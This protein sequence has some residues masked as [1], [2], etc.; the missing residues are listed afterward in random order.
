[1]VF[2]AIFALALSSHAHATFEPGWAEG[3]QAVNIELEHNLQAPDRH[4]PFYHVHPAPK[5]PGVYLWDSSFISLI[6][7]HHN[8]RIAKEVVQSV[9]VNQK[10]DGRIPQ[11]VSILGASKWTNPPVLSYA[12]AH[13]ASGTNDAEFAEK[14]Y[15]PLK[16]YQNWLWQARRLQNGLFFWDHAYESGLDNSPRFGKRDE[17]WYRDTKTLAAIDLSSYVVLDAHSMKTLAELV[18]TR[19]APGSLR[20]QELRNDISVYD[21]R[22]AEVTKL[23][24]EKLWDPATGYFYDLDVAT[25]RLQKIRTMAS[26]FPLIAGAATQ[27]QFLA[28][29]QH[30]TNPQEFN[31][32]IPVP[33]VARNSKWF[34]KDCWRGPVW[35]NTAYLVIKGLD[36]YNDHALAQDFSRRLINGV[37]NTWRVT[38]QFVEFYDPDRYDFKELTRKKGLG[39]LGLSASHD[40]V[41]IISHLIGKQLVLGS[42][43]VAHFI[44]WTGLVNTLAI[45]EFE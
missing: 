11:N 1:M 9:L 42:K 2:S 4:Y 29:R 41:E 28:L 13:I 10:P 15:E 44:G 14:V 45:E 30:L 32:K 27:E 40:P 3:F 35:V 34:E 25:N 23:I 26:F 18:L 21:E 7:E 19:T 8:P 38:G 20:A 31:T 39:P 22:A 33:T 12:A 6:W 5:Y 16:R 36:R 37:Y 17:S 24:Q 43:P